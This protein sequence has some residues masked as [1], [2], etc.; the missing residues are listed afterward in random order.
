MQMS[1]LETTDLE[2]TGTHLEFRFSRASDGKTAV[3][4]SVLIQTLE[5]AQRAI[6]LIALSREHREIKSRARIPADIEQ[7]Y[8][9]KCEVPVS[10][11]YLLPAF[12]ES[13]Q[14]NLLPLSQVGNVL[15]DFERIA[16]SLKR[17]NRDEVAHYLPDTAIRRRVVDAFQQLGPKP[18]SGWLLDIGQNGNSVRL[19]DGWQGSIRRMYSATL[20]EPDIETVNSELIGI[21][22]ANRQLTIL[23]LASVR[24]KTLQVTYPDD[25]EDF[26]LENRKSIIQITG[27]TL[28]DEN[29]ELKSLFDLEAIDPLDLAPLQ[30]TDIQYRDIHLKFLIPLVIEPQLSDDKNYITLQDPNLGIDIFAG[31]VSDLV[32]ELAEALAMSWKNYAL[33]EDAQLSP[34][35]LALKQRLLA[36]LTEV[37]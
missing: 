24:Q 26:L 4:A 17:G 31:I 33:A 35:A 25:L 19:D 7:R 14:P 13:G 3:P 30:F 22:F 37:A 1:T 8:Q 27:R 2:Q 36:A 29:D 34:K 20:S 28:R 12:V 6:W 11:S 23:P 32:D 15:A 9:L 21:D 18:G 5:G 16:D 10:G